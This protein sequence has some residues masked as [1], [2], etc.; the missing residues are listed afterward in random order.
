MIRREFITLLG[1]AAMAWPRVAHAQQPAVP[2]IGFL[3]STSSADSGQL[4]AA[5]RQ[6]LLSDLG[7]PKIAVFF[8]SLL[9]QFVPQATANPGGAYFFDFALLG[10]T[11]AAITLAWLVFYTY[12]LSRA[13]TCLT[14]PKVRR[15]LEAVTGAVLVTLGIRLATESR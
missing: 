12:L 15:S 9:P 11:F 2:V 3:R 7:N 1:G 6:G 8:A 4:V 10:V 13:G 5:F 14:R